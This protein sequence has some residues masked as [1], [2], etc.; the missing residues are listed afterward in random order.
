MVRAGRRGRATA[1][2][3]APSRPPP[4]RPSAGRGPTRVTRVL[5]TSGALGWA[6]VRRGD[7]GMELE[8]GPVAATAARYAGARVP[9]VE[10]GRLLTG[11]GTFV[12]DVMRP[13]MLHACFVRSPFARAGI[14]GIDTTAA[15]AMA[16]VRAVFVAGDLNPDAHQAWYTMMGPDVPDTPRPPMAEGEARFVGDPVAL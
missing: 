4:A 11:R 8:G 15:R 12:D 7:V 9:R 5:E 13:G 3:A 14:L 6:P 10:D 2:P 1:A 16:G